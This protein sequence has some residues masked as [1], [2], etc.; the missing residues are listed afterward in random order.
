M[1]GSLTIDKETPR[2]AKIIFCIGKEASGW[3]VIPWENQMRI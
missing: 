1:E 2:E 3:S